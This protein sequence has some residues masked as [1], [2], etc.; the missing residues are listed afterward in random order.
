M[1]IEGSPLVPK[2]AF[3]IVDLRQNLAILQ[4]YEPIRKTFIEVGV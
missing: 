4:T 1:G 3:Q 2:T